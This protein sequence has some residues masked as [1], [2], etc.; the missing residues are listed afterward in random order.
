MVGGFLLQDYRTMVMRRLCLGVRDN[1]SRIGWLGGMFWQ[2]KVCRLRV[3]R[4][5][6]KKN[7][8]AVSEKQLREMSPRYISKTYKPLLR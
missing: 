3:S 4:V 7:C 5:L 2:R 1:L 6:G 8:A